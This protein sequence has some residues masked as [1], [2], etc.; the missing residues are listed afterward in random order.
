MFSGIV[1]RVG[2]VER[3]EREARGLRLTIAAGFA[4][5]PAIGASVSVN[6]VCLTV[7]RAAEGRFES[8][9]VPETLRATTL[10]DLNAGDRVNLERALRLG[11]EL[12]GHWVQGH[13]DGVGRVTAVHRESGDVRVTI[14]VPDSVRRFV[15]T[16]GSI[17]VDG[18]SLTVARWDEP[19]L[20][21]ALVPHTLERTTAL[22]YRP[23]RPVNLESDLVA[24]TLERLLEA[25]GLL[26]RG[27][28]IP[29]PGRNS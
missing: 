5:D 19:S 21:V 27:S 20:T 22:E 7:E 18:V 23:G 6:G 1:E 28:G 12:G 15:A 14:D 10:G 25:R 29:L 24:R 4:D 9:A 11:D 17:T 26:E 3:A 8:V 2:T 13:V 16:K